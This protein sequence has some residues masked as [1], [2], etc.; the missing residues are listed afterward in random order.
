MVRM[1]FSARL[2]V[3]SAVVE[4]FEG[5]PTAAGERREERVRGEDWALAAV[6]S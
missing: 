3:D 2:A 1:A 6:R 5:S 4:R